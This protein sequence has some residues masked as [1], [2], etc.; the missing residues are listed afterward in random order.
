MH[1]S[2]TMVPKVLIPEANDPISKVE[3]SA[4]TITALRAMMHEEI[5]MGSLKWRIASVTSCSKQLAT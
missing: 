1:S 2:A 3:M 4:A 5:K